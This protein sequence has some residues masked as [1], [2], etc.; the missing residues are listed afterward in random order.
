MKYCLYLLPVEIIVLTS[1]KVLFLVTKAFKFLPTKFSLCKLPSR[2]LGITN[3]DKRMRLGR[4]HFIFLNR[5][6]GRF[7]LI[8]CM[9]LSSPFPVKLILRPLIGPQMTWSVQGLALVNPPSLLQRGIKG[10]DG[11]AKGADGTSKQNLFS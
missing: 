2:R 5:P 10:A 11:A 9:Y 4:M 8:V 7:F 3:G 1:Y 6:L